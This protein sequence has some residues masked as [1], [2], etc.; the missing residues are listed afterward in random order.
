MRLVAELV[1]GSQAGV[2]G[3]DRPRDLGALERA[4]DA[5]A[6]PLALDAG[7]VV[8]RG[9]R[10]RLGEGE[11]RVAD[12]L[13]P[14][15]RHERR[16]GPVASSFEIVRP[17]LV[18]RSHLGALLA[19]DVGIRLTC[20]LVDAADRVGALGPGGDDDAFGR[21]DLGPGCGAEVEREGRVSPDLR[22]PAAACPVQRRRVPLVDTPVARASDHERAPTPT[23]RRRARSPPLARAKARVRSRRSGRPRARRA[24]RRS[25]DPNRHRA[26]RSLPEARPSSP[27]GGASRSSSRA[28]PDRGT[29]P[30]C[31]PRANDRGPL[32]RPL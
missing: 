10:K 24:T 13:G 6:S 12:D 25:R 16:L 15:Q 3:V 20:D 28:W 17:P 21:V 11:L 31:S 19:R 26:R 7:H 2:A 22:E 18:E 14:G 32:R 5:A 30:R 9:V 4:G 29:G 23:T 27:P 8:E 1:E